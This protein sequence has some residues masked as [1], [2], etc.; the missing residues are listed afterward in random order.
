MHS[1][2]ITIFLQTNRASSASCVTYQ[3]R[4]FWEFLPQNDRAEIVDYQENRM[5][6]GLNIPEKGALD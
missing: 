4:G 3:N 6:Y 1:A 2:V 5:K